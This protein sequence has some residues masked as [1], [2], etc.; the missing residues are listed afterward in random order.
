MSPSAKPLV[1]ACADSDAGLVFGVDD[2]V[3]LD[4]MLGGSSE[5][6]GRDTNLDDAFESPPRVVVVLAR[7]GTRETVIRGE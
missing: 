7:E 5:R 1:V 2:E 4:A 6:R 3:T